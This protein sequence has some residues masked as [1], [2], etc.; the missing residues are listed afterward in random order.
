MIVYHYFEIEQEEGLEQSSFR[1]II[2]RVLIDILLEIYIKKIHDDC[3][4]CYY[5]KLNL[6]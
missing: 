1:L 6:I 3:S 2:F 5:S 4:I